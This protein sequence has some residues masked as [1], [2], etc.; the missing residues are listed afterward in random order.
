MSYPKNRKRWRLV[1]RAV[2]AT[3]FGGPEVLE[4]REVPEPVPGPGEVLVD[5]ATADVMFLDTRLRSGWGT[6]FFPVEPPYVPGGAVAGVVAAVGPEVDPSWVGR[7]G[8]HANGAQ[9]GRRW[10]ADRWIRGEVTGQG[11]DTDPGAR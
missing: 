10:I 4:V 5:V 9:R 6:D 11:R 2:Y 8:Q 7:M 3:K 1:M